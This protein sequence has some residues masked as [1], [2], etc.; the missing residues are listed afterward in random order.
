M[1]FNFNAPTSI[2]A[3]MNGRPATRK[4]VNTLKAIVRRCQGRGREICDHFSLPADDIEAKRKFHLPGST[5]DKPRAKINNFFTGAGQCDSTIAKWS[6][7]VGFAAEVLG[8]SQSAAADHLKKILA[9]DLNDSP[10]D[11]FPSPPAAAKPPTKKKLQPPELIDWKPLKLKML[12]NKLGFDHKRCELLKEAGAEMAVWGKDKANGKK[13]FEVLAI[14][15]WGQ[16]GSKADPIGWQM[17]RLDGE[18]WKL[19]DEFQTTICAAGSQ[20]GIVG[21][22]RQ[23][24]DLL[25]GKKPTGPV[26]KTEGV[27]DFLAALLRDDLPADAM[28]WTNPFG[29][30]DANAT[31]REAAWSLEA[32]KDVEVAIVHD[33]DRPGQQGAIQWAKQ[34]TSAGAT[35]RN[36][37]LPFDVTESHGKDLRDFFTDG[38]TF[39][40]L[41]FHIIEAEPMTAGHIAEAIEA[42][43]ATAS[44][45]GS[46][47][48]GTPGDAG[49]D[50]TAG[51]GMNNAPEP[52]YRPIDAGEMVRATDRGNIG[53]VISD[54][55]ES[56]TVLFVGED[57]T[58]TKEMSKSELQTMDGRSLQISAS[59]S[60]TPIPFNQLLSENPELRPVLVDDILRKG[61]TMNIIAAAKVGKSHLAAGLAWSVAT[62]RPWLGHEVV[63]SRV[64][65]IDNELHA[66]TLAHR[67][68]RI[69][70]EMMIEFDERDS[71]DVVCL[72]GKGMDIKGIGEQLEK[73]N[74]DH[75]GLIVIDALYR[76]LPEK[77]SESDNAH[78]MMIYNRLDQ[79]AF[80]SNAAVAVVHHASKG[81]QHG[82]AVTDVG[83]GAGSISRAA[84]T[85]L[86]IRPHEQP[87]LA[88]L[89]CK[90]RSFDD[91]DPISIKW[92]WPMWSLD[93]TKPEVKIPKGRGDEKRNS[94]KKETERKV[95]EILAG[96]MT[97]ES[98]QPA[99]LEDQWLS[100]SSIH[101]KTDFSRDR[102]RGA[103]NRL[104]DSESIEAKE[105]VNPG[106]KTKKIDFYRGKRDAISG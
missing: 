28:I 35:I 64:L 37:L 86:V 43:E 93:T 89:E 25:A 10:A 33:A 2:A 47:S 57:G 75:Y 78:M 55:G 92:E 38:G 69:A 84:D 14:P 67:L 88:V 26:I 24:D 58:M 4:P 91:P 63:E 97:D 68:N 62:G 106:N 76:T 83:S 19:G 44:G 95:L 59:A 80:Q 15:T 79:I 101:K 53:E 85:H 13:G 21:D 61:E 66:G 1:S 27:S 74:P 11:C 7:W 34:L 8:C 5:A 77:T 104:L 12:F 72:R 17:I 99:E 100:L 18:K 6:D 29:C 41:D 71:I 65:I 98:G 20:R 36:V 42:N 30:R 16:H 51:E 56:C 94:E 50:R 45:E 49:A 31:A 60:F 102:V 22:I 9:I 32:F 3:T 23:I 87:G 90:C 48:A 82:K 40:E 96:A 103:V 73:L 81:D 54:N 39:E 70:N 105:G 46:S 52:S